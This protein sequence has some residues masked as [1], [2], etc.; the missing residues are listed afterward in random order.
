MVHSFSTRERKKP[1]EEALVKRIKHDCDLTG[2]T[3]SFVILEAL[4]DYERAGK[5]QSHK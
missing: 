3:F 1:E 2:R 4:A 5:V